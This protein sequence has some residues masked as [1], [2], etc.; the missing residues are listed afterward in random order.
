MKLLIL[1]ILGF[2]MGGTVSWKINMEITGKAS[3]RNYIMS[4]KH[5]SIMLILNR[6]LQIK[7]EQ[8][9]I[10][11][12]LENKGIHTV[13][14]Y[15]MS[16]VGERL[17]EELKNENV[18]VLYGIDKKAG[19]GIEGFQMYSPYE[20]LPEV[21]AVIVTPTFFFAAIQKDLSAKIMC[22][23]ISLEEILYEV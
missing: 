23:I 19:S 11:A 3:S 20:K 18:Q 12:Y 2:I 7:Q 4:E 21:D 22:P 8:K 15:G 16:Y 13:A 1:F 9:S 14:I 17:Y 5:L 6:F 10:G